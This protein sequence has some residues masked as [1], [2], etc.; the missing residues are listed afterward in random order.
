GDGV[1]LL[2]PLALLDGA[3]IRAALAAETLEHLGDVAVHGA[4]DSTN[5][6]LLRRAASSPIHGAVHLAEYQTAGRGRRGNAWLAP[7]GSAVC[8]SVGWE[9][10]TLRSALSRFSV[11]LGIEIARALRAA[12]LAD[13]GVKWPNDI[14]LPDGKLGGILVELQELPRGGIAII[15]GIGLNVRLSGTLRADI[16]QPVTDL[17]TALGRPPDR[18]VL[19]ALVIDAAVRTLRAVSLDCLDGLADWDEFDT[20]LGRRVRIEATGPGDEDAEEGVAAGIDASGALRLR[21][22][23]SCRSIMAGHVV[24]LDRPE[25]GG[26]A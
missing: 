17:E 5:A 19:A 3:A 26:A 22:G 20:L 10:D 14:V 12:G 2:N 6:E 7:A 4:V 16:Q 13:A 11:M 23:T 15:T 24:P 8:L 9:I 1:R 25:P 18:N 21:Q